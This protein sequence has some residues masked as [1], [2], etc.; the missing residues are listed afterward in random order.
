MSARPTLKSIAAVMRPVPVAPAP[1]APPPEKNYRTAATRT[2]TRQLSGHFPAGD[3]QAFRIMAEEQDKDVGEMLAEAINMAF[4]RYGKPN[5]IQI[6][7][8]RRKR[9]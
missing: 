1:A 7:S 4:E 8:G 2:A 5:R 9:F 3:V 6:V